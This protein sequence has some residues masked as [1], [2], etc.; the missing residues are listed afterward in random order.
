LLN[1]KFN[2]EFD[3]ATAQDFAS[4]LAALLVAAPQQDA[5]RVGALA[6]QHVPAPPRGARQKGGGRSCQA[7]A[8]KKDA[9]QVPH[10]MTTKNRLTASDRLFIFNVI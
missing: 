5:E 9:P 10:V 6:G 4:Q 2:G 3:E 7:R 1:L 8:A